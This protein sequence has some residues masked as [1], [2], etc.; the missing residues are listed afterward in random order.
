LSLLSSTNSGLDNLVKIS[1]ILI[2]LFVGAFLIGNFNPYFEGVDSYGYA[3]AA[4]QFSQ[5]NLF[6]TN[7]LIHLGFEELFPP[8]MMLTND[9]HHLLWAGY[10]GFFG[11]ATLSYTIAGNYGL[12]YLGPIAGILFLIIAERFSTHFFGKYV[13]LLTLVFLS[14][15]HFLFRSALNLQTEN[16]FTIFFLVGCFFLIKFFQKKSLTYLFISS[17]LFV[18]TSLLRTNGVIYFPIELLLVS[19]FVILCWKKPKIIVNTKLIK[20]I[21]Q[22]NFVTKKNILK[23]FVVMLIPWIIFFAFYFSYYDTFFD[24]PFTNN[25]ELEKGDSTEVKTSSLFNLESKNLENIKQYSKYLLPYQFPRIIDTGSY[26]SDINQILGDNWLG[27]V[28]LL[29]LFSFLVLSIVQKNHRIT[30]IVFAIMILGTIWFFSSITSEDRA[31]RGVPGRYMFPAFTLFYMMI[32]FTIIQFFNYN[33]FKSNFK[34]TCLKIFKSILFVTL[35]LFFITSFYYSPPIEAIKNN[36]FMLKDPGLFD[37][38]YPLD[39]EGLSANDVLIGYNFE[40]LDYGLIQFQPEVSLKDEIISPES[41][42]LLKQIMDENYKV[43]LIKNP[44]DNLDRKV[45][46]IFSNHQEFSIKE[47]SKSFC[48]VEL[49]LVTEKIDSKNFC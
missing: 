11:L 42:N 7:D 47:Y 28:S 35:I 5:G 12:F 14:T 19:L 15:N 45:Y 23:V 31:L 18:F 37:Q 3:I 22:T 13:G 36:S 20:N 16:I 25:V 38:R 46:S 30:F 4:K 40:A 27:I 43:Y 48:K 2:I 24:D 41:I 6:Y 10:A 32:S 44:T 29:L 34:I 49:G 21:N 9:G 33:P 26:F 8:D 17:S 1:K 39:K